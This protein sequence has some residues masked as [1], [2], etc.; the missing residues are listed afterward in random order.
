ME[1]ILWKF[2]HNVESSKHCYSKPDY[3]SEQKDIEHF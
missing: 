1:M 3:I 2:L